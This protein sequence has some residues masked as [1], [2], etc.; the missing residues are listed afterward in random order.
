M[1]LFINPDGVVPPFRLRN[2]TKRLPLIRKPVRNPVGVG[3]P[4]RGGATLPVTQQNEAVARRVATP[5]G[6]GGPVGVVPPF[7]LPNKTKRLP[8]GVIFYHR[9][10]GCSQYE[11][12]VTQEG[13]FR[14]TPHVQHTV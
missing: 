8:G 5:S 6:L 12:P 11:F 1:H 3:W 7:R 4:R 9:L 13:C 2:N 14:L 10:S